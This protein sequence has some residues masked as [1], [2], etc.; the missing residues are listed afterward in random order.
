MKVLTCPFGKKMP[1]GKPF[2]LIYAE[3]TCPLWPFAICKNAVALAANCHNFMPDPRMS[4]LRAVGVTLRN[5]NISS[6]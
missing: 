6:A 1:R 5:N 2:W 3:I 4:F